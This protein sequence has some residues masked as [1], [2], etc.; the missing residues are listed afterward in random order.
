MTWTRRSSAYSKFADDTK[1]CSEVVKLDE[2]DGIQKDVDKLRDRS[3]GLGLVKL[4]IV[5]FGPSVQPVQVPLQ[6]PATLQQINTASQ[7]GVICEFANGRDPLMQVIKIKILNRIGPT[8]IPQGQHWVPAGCNII[9][10]RSLGLAILTVL[11]PPESACPSCGLTA[12]PEVCCGRW[13]EVPLPRKL[14]FKAPLTSLA[15][16]SG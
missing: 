4:P 11:N 15:S 12:F 6:S 3:V 8:L 9:P 14:Y 7:L 1:L 2:K 13:I 10:H 5:G 16:L